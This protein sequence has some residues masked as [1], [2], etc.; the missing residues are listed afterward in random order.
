MSRS[1]QARLLV[2]FLV[3]IAAALG[4]VGVSVLLVGPGYFTEAMGHVPGDPLGEIMG[5]APWR[6]ALG[7]LELSILSS[8]GRHWS[9]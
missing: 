2:A 7:S 4:T 3:V 8:T 5:E 9:L 6:V 1:L